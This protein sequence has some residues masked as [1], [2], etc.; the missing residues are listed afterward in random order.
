MSCVKQHGGGA[1]HG[2]VTNT[3]LPLLRNTQAYLQSLLER[4]NPDS[5]LALAWQEFYQTYN[6]LIRRFVIAYGIRNAEVDDCVQDIW[7]EVAQRLVDFQHPGNRPGLRAWLYRVVRSTATDL[8]RRKARLAKSLEEELAR[9][10]EPKSGMPDPA[11]V[12]ELKWENAVLQTA[13]DDLRTKVSDLNHRVLKMRLFAGCSVSEV[14]DALNL[15]PTQVRYRQHRTL[16]KLR[17]C[18]AK[19]L[20]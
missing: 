1:S 10:E 18:V 5:V 6:G 12:Y 14:A 9:G 8:V 19:Y 4:R 2:S 15:T 20:A 11:D 17:A 16:N 3:Y 13:M 7:S